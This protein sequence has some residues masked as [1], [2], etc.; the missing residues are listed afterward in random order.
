MNK[1]LRVIFLSLIVLISGCNFEER[2]EASEGATY[3]GNQSDDGSSGDDGEDTDDSDTVDLDVEW[4]LYELVTLT[5]TGLLTANTKTVLEGNLLHVFYYDDHTAVDGDDELLYDVEFDLMHLV[6]DIT[7]SEIETAPEVVASLD[8]NSS[9]AAAL[10]TEVNV[11]YKGGEVRECQ[12]DEQSDAMISSLDGAGWFEETAAIGYVERQTYEPLQDGLA[13][14]AMSMAV[15]SSGNRH[16]AYQFYYEGC[17]TNPFLYPDLHYSVLDVGIDYIDRDAIATFEHEEQVDGNTLDTQD[18]ANFNELVGAGSV[19]KLLLD[20]NENPLVLYYAD[21]AEGEM[22]YGLKIAIRNG[23]DDWTK[24]WLVEDYEIEGLD[25]AYKSDGYL[26]VAF[27]TTNYVNDEGKTMLQLHYLEQT[28]D[29]WQA[30]ETMNTG[31]QIGQYPSLAFDPDGDPII[32]YY[33]I[34]S[35]AGNERNNLKVARKKNDSWYLE[36]VSTLSDIGKYNQLTVTDEG[37]AILVSYYATDGT[38]VLF[39]ADL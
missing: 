3:E 36:E 28:S 2:F 18:T 27:Y 23:A 16:I 10:G 34:E 37:K 11:I 22:E 30:L 15:D 17:D 35:Y 31:V 5:N 33:E 26:A 39:E 7:N 32:A 4:T 6:W 14:G 8:N 25:A 9:L 12:G 29:G 1:F 13:G 21:E 38:V 20:A 19:N 24:Q